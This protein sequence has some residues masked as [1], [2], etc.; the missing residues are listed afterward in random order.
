MNNIIY[1]WNGCIDKDTDYYV[2]IKPIVIGDED[3]M[4]C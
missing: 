4:P 1:C 3:F 2:I